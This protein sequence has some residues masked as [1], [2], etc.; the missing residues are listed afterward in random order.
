MAAMKKQGDLIIGNAIGSCIFNLLCVVG[1]TAAVAPISRTPELQNADLWIMVGL[2]ATILPFM[3]SRRRLA[4]AEGAVLLAGYL[5][6]FVY[7]LLRD[8]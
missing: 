4:R 3:W 6:Y 2:T 8:G 1:L 5:A 7:L